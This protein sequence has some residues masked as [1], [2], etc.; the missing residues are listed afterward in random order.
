MEDS[1]C[2]ITSFLQLA[3]HGAFIHHLHPHR[4]LSAALLDKFSPPNITFFT[5]SCRR[6]LAEQ[7]GPPLVTYAP[8]V[9]VSG[10][11]ERN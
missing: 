5:R 6:E 2:I 8:W 10:I 9:K 11:G 7:T 4:L 3:L 1:A